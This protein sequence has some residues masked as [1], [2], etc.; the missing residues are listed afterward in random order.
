MIFRSNAS[1]TSVSQP[2]FIRRIV[3]GVIL[4]NLFVFALIGYSLHENRAQHVKI[5]EITTQ[6]LSLV[7]EQNIGNSITK[8]D[9]T[10]LA[11]KDEIEK[12]LAEGG[13][14]PQSVKSFLSR[15]LSRLLKLDGLRV[16][17]AHGN[18]AYG[19]DDRNASRICIGDREY[20]K[21]HR[22]T[23]QGGLIISKPLVSRVTG[24]WSLI[25]SRRLNQKDGAFAGVVY[26]VIS[27]ERYSRLFSSIDIGKHG[28]ITLRG[29]DM[30]VV[31]RYSSTRES[32]NAVGQKVVSGIYRAM[33]QNGLRSGTFKSLHPVD[34][35]ER[36]HTFRK[37]SSYPLFINIGIAAMDYLDEWRS[38]VARMLTIAVLFLF[39]S[40]IAS[41]LIFRNWKRSKAAVKALARQEFKFRTIAD[42]TYDWEFWMGPDGS[43]I[44]TSPS[45]KRITG[46]DS[47]E[48]YSDPGLLLRIL[49]PDDLALFN[50]H[51]RDM[52]EGTRSDSLVYRIVH[53]DGNIRW[54]EHVCQAIIDETGNFL[55]IRSSIRDI[56]ERKQAE[57]ELR[58]INRTLRTLTKCNETLVRAEDESDLLNSLCRV[59]VEDG[60]YCFT[61]VGFTENDQEKAIRPVAFSGMED[62]Y[63]EK[64]HIT[65]SD[66]ERGRGPGG[67][68]VR[69][70]QTCQVKDIASDPRFELWR[71]QALSRGYRSSL[72]IPLIYAD[73]A[74]GI[75]NI[76]AAEPDAFDDE[77]IVLMNQLANDMSY[78]ISSLRTREKQKRTVEALWESAEQYRN[79]AIKRDQEHSLLRALIDSV[80]D[81]IFFK[82]P[83]GG[84]MGCNKAFEIFTGK[85]EK[86]IVG[87]N[88][89]EL[90]PR[91]VGE[92]FREMDCKMMSHRI[93][94]RNEEWVDYPDGRRLLLETLKT[95]FY[96]RD[97]K[98]LGLIGI[99]RDITERKR[100]EEERNKLAGQLQQAQ[101]MEA[102]GQLAGGIAHDFNNI[103]TAIIGYS[104]IILMRMDKENPLRHFVDQ[105]FSSAERAA[106]LTKD[107]LAFSRK[108]VLHTHPMNLCQILDDL[109][110]MLD[111]LIPE[112]IEFRTTHVDGEMTVLADKGQIEQVIMNL[113]TNARDAMPRGGILSVDISHVSMDEKFIHAHGFGKPGDYA[114][115][116]VT[117]SGHG[118]DAETQLKIFEPFFTT[119]E[120]GKGTGLGMSII[121]GIIKQHNGYVNV[122]SKV[123][124][125]TTFKV[126]LPLD[127]GNRG[128][129]CNVLPAVTAMGGN[130]TILL[131]EDDETVRGLHRMILEDAGYAVIEAVDGQDALDRFMN[132]ESVIAMVVSD[133]IMPKKD[134]K[135]LLT[136]IRKACPDIKVLFM[137]GYTRD[138]VIERG[139][140]DD[141]LN[142]VAKPVM[143]LELLG[144]V[145]QIL[146]RK[147]FCFSSV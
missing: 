72:A 75:I 137:S 105:V 4:V 18:I 16:A 49:H 80:P 113:V 76:Y 32:G 99:S 44:H 36:I 28:T 68:A 119:K 87:L 142:F 107:L 70:G 6:N 1:D 90:F 9:L 95:P 146:D 30:E 96:D 71:D 135:S 114:L 145:R 133:V 69:T 25:V 101:K 122:Y 20:F 22:E 24:K 46:F 126:Y 64:L 100:A 59:I 106:D 92:A 143:P 79:L 35:I 86:S 55:G 62:G 73:N 132:C 109:R 54:I 136:E 117:D 48:F 125:G 29:Q 5:A 51:H 23:D 129:T 127:S 33:V 104:Q 139:A 47:G 21:M 13:I 31:A 85:P 131:V 147:S 66:C 37:I 42:F 65:W 38:E 50:E 2:V 82:N 124:R 78:G 26:G 115:I 111:R 63:L 116:S 134:G 56:T 128:D 97:G 94:S 138:I 108:Q 15:Q 88:D 81:L 112:D 52:S 120:V 12:Q 27:L 34:N 102:V 57:V 41:L 19:V 91:E 58:R 67:I 103:L 89:I 144:K 121:Y 60:G 14:S 77:E 17:D 130:E 123:G 40:I 141:E 74:L 83:E 53:A 140:L 3:A 118:M 11:T 10:L 84:Y 93:V 8:L 7:L 61:W 43:C 110:K 98:L 45:C 39:I